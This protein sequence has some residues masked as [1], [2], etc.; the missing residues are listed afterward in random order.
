MMANF[1]AKESAALQYNQPFW[2]HCCGADDLE[3]TKRNQ[4]TARR[5]EQEHQL[6]SLLYTLKDG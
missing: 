2:L 3:G 4:H 6:A 5:Q 1:N